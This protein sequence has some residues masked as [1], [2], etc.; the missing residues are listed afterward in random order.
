MS[1]GINIWINVRRRRKALGIHSRDSRSL[2]VCLANLFVMAQKFALTQLSLTS[3]PPFLECFLTC[4]PGLGS[5]TLE[6][7]QPQ[8]L[9]ALSLTTV[10]WPGQEPW[11]PP[12]AILLAC[13]YNL[14]APVTCDF[15][16]AALRSRVWFTEFPFPWQAILEAEPYLMAE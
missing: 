6:L 15:W 10:R 9:A 2:A 7:L 4:V 1:I 3:G 13:P 5:L 11:E 14:W 16:A 12:H 8:T